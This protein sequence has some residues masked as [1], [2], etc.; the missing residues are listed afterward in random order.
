VKMSGR[1]N[2]LY[3]AASFAPRMEQ[4]ASQIQDSRDFP[5]CSELGIEHHSFNCT[6]PN[7]PESSC[8]SSSIVYWPPVTKVFTGPLPPR[9]RIPLAHEDFTLRRIQAHGE[10]ERPF[11]SGQPVRLLACARALILEIE[12]ERRVNLVYVET[13]AR[14]DV[15]GLFTGHVHGYDRVK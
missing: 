2:S 6:A 10:I 5:F 4:A 3:F 8:Q 12:V 13:L 11:G 14:L 9:R 15:G 7:S 1:M